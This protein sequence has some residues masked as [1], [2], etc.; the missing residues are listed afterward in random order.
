MYA[1]RSIQYELQ[2]QPGLFYSTVVLLPDSTC[3]WKRFVCKP[4]KRCFVIRDQEHND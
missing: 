1:V 4:E 2:L 3:R